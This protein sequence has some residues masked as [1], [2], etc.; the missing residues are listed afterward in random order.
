MIFRKS[1]ISDIFNIG[2]SEEISRQRDSKNTFLNKSNYYSKVS[3]IFNYIYEDLF[4]EIISTKNKYIFLKKIVEKSTII[5]HNNFS[6]DELKLS[7]LKNIIYKV[8]CLLLFTI[9]YNYH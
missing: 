1:K 7:I 4:S 6:D 2:N 3:D 5:I 9:K 8:N